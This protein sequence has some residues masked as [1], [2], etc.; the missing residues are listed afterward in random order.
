MTTPRPFRFG[1]G[2]NSTTSREE[3]INQARQAE[4]L[5]Y[6]TFLIPDHFR[7]ALAP[8]AA[9][10]A[11]A[12]ATQTLRVG[13]FV[14]DND[15]RHPA[16]LAK[17]AATLDLL[18]NGRFEMGI[19]A[20]WLR[21][22]YDETG[23]PYDAPGVRIKR[24]EEALHVIKAIWTEETATYSGN[25]YKITQLQGVPKPAQRPHPPILIG[26]GGK[27]VLSLA[28]RF[29][30]IV[31]FI[32]KLEESGPTADLTDATETALHEKIA[33]VREAASERFQQLELNLFLA[34]VIVTQD[35]QQAAQYIAQAR[36]WQD[37][38]AEQILAVPYLLIGTIEQMVERLHA[39]REKFGLSYFVIPS[40][41]RDQFAPV[42]ARL[43]GV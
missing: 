22:E 17:E 21:S 41:N 15:F 24:L 32:P 42:V 12:D 2:G 33:W 7:Q 40:E 26:G 16:V 18:S 1:L 30:N 31:G 13:S 29:A 3:W 39:L 27:R 10:M 19:G 11:A 38:N 14:F 43:A 4:T 20:G 9:L 35:Q 25:F 5:G 23:I 6:S 8:I 36:G 28:G 37:M 34:A